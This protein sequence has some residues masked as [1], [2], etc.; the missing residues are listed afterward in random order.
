MATTTSTPCSGYKGKK[1]RSWAELPAEIVRLIATHYLHDVSAHGFCPNTWDAREQWPRRMVYTT[2][3]DAVE[4]DKLM[5]ICTAWEQA[6]EHHP[7]WQHAYI[8]LDPH[9]VRAADRVIAPAPMA[10]T[11]ALATP[12]RVSH[13][14]HFRNLFELACLPCRI[15]N[16]YHTYQYGIRKVSIYS[17]H[18]GSIGICKEHFRKAGFC[19]I[20]LRDAPF[21]ELDSDYAVVCPIEDGDR[22]WGEGVLNTCRQCR[23]EALWSL[24]FNNP[25]DREAIGGHKL[26]SADWETRQ[27]VESFI[28]LGEGK[29]LDVLAIAREKQ[30]LRKYTKLVDMLEQAV[31]ASKYV[32]RAEAGDPGYGTDEEMSEDED[33]DAELMSMTEDA[34]GIRE[35]A[36]LDWARSRILD[37]L[38]ISPQDQFYSNV[39]PGKPWVVPAYHP[40]PWNPDAVYHG[41]LADGT[42]EADAEHT[43]HPTAKTTRVETIPTVMLNEQAEVAF[44]RSMRDIMLPAMSNLVRR[45]VIEC[46]ADGVD[47]AL[48]ASKLSLEDVIQQLRD[49]AMWYN[50][51]DWIE[52]RRNRTRDERRDRKRSVERQ[53]SEED[54]SSSSSRSEGS[55]TTSPVLSTTTLQTTPSPPPAGDSASKE[56]ENDR[57]PSST[58]APA[59]PIPVAPV[60]ASPQ[61]IHPIPYIPETTSHLPEWSAY[62]LASVWKEASAPLFQCR[63]SICERT[64]LRM[65]MQAGNM[66]ASQIALHPSQTR[67]TGIVMN[68]PPRPQTPPRPT[69]KAVEVQLDEAIALGTMTPF[70]KEEEETD[71][72]ISGTDSGESEKEDD[73]AS[74]VTGVPHTV[75]SSVPPSVS[76][77]PSSPSSR[78]RSSSDVDG[79]G[80]VE[81]IASIERSGTPPKKARIDGEY[82]PDTVHAH[83]APTQK[84]SGKMASTISSPGRL[85]KRSS[86]EL[87]DGVSVGVEGNGEA[88]RHKS[89]STTVS[90]TA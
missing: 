53:A 48:R 85:K 31:A 37:G 14:K 64:M 44:R 72:L 26:A 63:C 34:G 13:Y 79:E 46:T 35:I 78:K 24:V 89:S 20:C 88:K 33:D 84:A 74:S 23:M 25:S 77:A 39:V 32:A 54:D 61:L 83:L 12:T 67:Q 55:H 47:P 41:G 68:T 60:L 50:G 57:S 43:I 82:S 42:S 4:M 69:Q 7:F 81:P 2:V 80:D 9:D 40:C 73:D 27:A 86:E 65:N 5:R 76:P 58:T 75:P 59:I 1:L 56:D 28:D 51:I 45:I 19:S 17:K 8:V 70:A 36:L 11:A 62:A 49:E 29:L 6:L 15:N 10:G 90:G 38:W 87:E 52:R 66:L 18:F 3:R 30:W 71:S 16:P 21:V 22:A